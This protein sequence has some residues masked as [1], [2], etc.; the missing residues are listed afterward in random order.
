MSPGRSVLRVVSSPTDGAETDAPLDPDYVYR[1]YA[2]YVAA[3]AFRLL[4]RQEE[5]DDSVQEVFLQTLRGL[6]TIRD[7]NAIKGWLA[8]V[9]VRVV[10]RRLRLRRLRTF[11]GLD[12]PGVGELASDLA[13]PEQRTLLQQVY[14]QLD[15]MA[16][17]LRIAWVLRHVE[18]DR[19][20]DVALACGCSLATAKRRISG[21]ERHLEEALDVS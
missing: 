12:H 19:L 14:E 20:D 15:R 8:K 17:D 18:G 7:P 4:G 6:K 21:A 1:R 11:L 9:T 3:V 5:V 10:R 2:P 16:P 13:T